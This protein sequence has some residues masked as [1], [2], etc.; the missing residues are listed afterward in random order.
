MSSRADCSVMTAA[1]PQKVE[2]AIAK[3]KSLQDGDT[4]VIDAIACGRQAVPALRRILFERER[5]GLYQTRRRAV[6]ALAGLAASDV[7]IEFLETD[8]VYRGPGRAGG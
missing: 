7:L 8:R 1:E 4:G 2:R 3:L 5:S 6:E